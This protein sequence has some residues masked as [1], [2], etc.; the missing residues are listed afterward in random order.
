MKRNANNIKSKAKKIKLLL[1]DCDGVL[2]DGRVYYSERGEEM[3]I[4]SLRDGMGVERLRKLVDV[5]TGIISGENSEILLRRVEKLN[6]KEYYFGIKDKL[7]KFIEILEKNDL[8]ADEIAYIG[9]DCNDLEIMKHVGLSAC[10]SNATSEIKKSANLIMDSEGGY[11]AFRD[12]AE[13]I[14]ENKLK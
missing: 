8:S 5:D 11:G 6:I 1:T 13:V 14:I 2:T 7:E 9:D 12:F 10:P 3:K 4:F